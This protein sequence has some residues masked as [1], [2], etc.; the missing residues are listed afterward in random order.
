MLDPGM[1]AIVMTFAIPIVAIRASQ[2]V[3]L[4][5]LDLERD[6]LAGLGTGGGVGLVE[7]REKQRALDERLLRLEKVTEEK[8]LLEA[9][10]QNLETIVCSVDFELNQRLNRL[11][12]EA[13]RAGL[14]QAPVARAAALGGHDAGTAA[15]V[16][17]APE[18]R[19]GM[20]PF[21]GSLERGQTLVGRYTIERELGR[22][23]M[24]AVY[25]AHDAQLAERVALKVIASTL[26]SDPVG[27]AERFRREVAAARKITHPNVIRI[28]DLGQ[29]GSLLFLSMEFVEGQTLAA[30]LAK[31]GL[32]PVGAGL[33]LW[34]QLCDGVAAAHAA[35]V[36]HRD[37]KPQNVLLTPERRAKIIDFGLANATSFAGNGMTAT[38][39]ILGTPEYMAPEQVRG[40]PCDARTDVYA[41]GG[42]GYQLFT[43]RPPFSGDTPIAVGFAQVM[44]P[45]RPIAELR[46]ELPPSIAA[47]VM[48]ALE[49]EP[50]KRQADA[51]EL[52]RAIG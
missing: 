13:S 50:E 31:S 24:G 21:A 38:G 43:G 1:I 17:L 6:R 5:K 30:H 3:K 19:G 27:A 14:L 4:K 35:G 12:M 34:R 36:I 47:A 10:V 11:A 39:M 18:T 9:R 22:G 29:D 37:L 20:G 15:T 23:G 41:L 40:R 44:T 16:A 2:R 45:A 26:A 46:P 32:L 7:D 48:R 8:R 51:A 52:R 28:H 49:K 25:L 33:D 42:L